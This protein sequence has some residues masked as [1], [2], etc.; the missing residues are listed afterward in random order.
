MVVG[1]LVGMVGLGVEHHVVR[2][3]V[4]RA[5]A[6]YRV[7]VEGALGGLGQ[8][9]SS[10]L[11]QGGAQVRGDVDLGADAERDALGSGCLQAGPD[12]VDA[13]QHR[14]GQDVVR[15]DDLHGLFE[16]HERSP[17]LLGGGC[18]HVGE[19]L[20]DALGGVVGWDEDRAVPGVV[21][22][23][24]DQF[25]DAA[26]LPVLRTPGRPRRRTCPAGPGRT[27]RRSGR[28]SLPLP[29]PRMATG[30]RRRPSR[31]RRGSR[32]CRTAG[33]AC[34]RRIPARTPSGLRGSTRAG[35]RPGGGGPGVRGARGRSRGPARP[36]WPGW[37]GWPIR[38]ARL[39]C[40]PT[41]RR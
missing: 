4:E 20:V 29:T 9:E 32:G 13:A 41:G 39:P 30:R 15:A 37:R 5:E 3:V 26:D 27:R 28:S 12:H 11:N 17:A 14:V 31:S 24:D 34:G 8:Q 21:V 19:D 16:G 33:R 2:C 1:L 10:G 40:R 22:A 36:R 35:P 6:D 18:G 7:D 38:R 25:V 23:L